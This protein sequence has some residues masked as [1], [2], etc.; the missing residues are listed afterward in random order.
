MNII[1]NHHSDRFIPVDSV[2]LLHRSQSS[3]VENDNAVTFKSYMIVNDKLNQSGLTELSQNDKTMSIGPSSLSENRSHLFMRAP[4]VNRLDSFMKTVSRET[5][6]R[7]S[8]P[9][10]T[11]ALYSKRLTLRSCDLSEMMYKQ[12]LLQLDDDQL[13]Y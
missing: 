10:L 9:S 2:S 6:T 12:Q 7:E 13:Q 8:K 5:I 4:T 3:S 1:D 11:S